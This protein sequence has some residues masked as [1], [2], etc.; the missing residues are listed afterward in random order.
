MHVQSNRT[1]VSVLEKARVVKTGVSAVKTCCWGV[2]TCMAG[3]QKTW[4]E[5]KICGWRWKDVARSQDMWL[6][7]E[8]HGWA[9]GS[10]WVLRVERHGLRV[11]TCGWRSEYLARGRDMWLGVDWG[12]K[13]MTGVWNMWLGVNWGSKRVLRGEKHG[14]RVETRGWRSEYMAGES[15]HV[16]K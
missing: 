8:M 5:G 10:E 16:N 15:K 14:W 9:V 1:C 4:L 3:G 7:V 13:R 11:K 12:L 2:E 6:R